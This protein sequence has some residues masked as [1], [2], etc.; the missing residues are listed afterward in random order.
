MEIKVA[1]HGAEGIGITDFGDGAALPMDAKPVRRRHL[2]LADEQTVRQGGRQRD[3]PILR[4][5]LDFDGARLKRSHNA[6]VKAEEGEGVV[7][8]IDRSRHRPLHPVPLFAADRTPNVLGS[9]SLRVLIL[10]GN[11]KLENSFRKKAN[12]RILD[13]AECDVAGPDHATGYGPRAGRWPR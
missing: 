11:L 4:Y 5:D 2:M 7:Q 12:L 9:A 13:A 1:K 3:W 10:L 6:V 8:P